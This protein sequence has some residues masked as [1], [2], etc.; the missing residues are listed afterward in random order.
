[1]VEE[2]EKSDETVEER[3]LELIIL[4]YLQ[5]HNSTLKLDMYNLE[6]NYIYKEDNIVFGVNRI[7]ISQIR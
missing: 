5:I 1:M 7:K 4:I 3:M 2:K 6:G